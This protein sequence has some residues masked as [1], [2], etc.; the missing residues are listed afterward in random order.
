MNDGWRRYCGACGLALSPACKCGFVNTKHDRFCGGCGTTM[1]KPK[2]V[3]LPAKTIPID[4]IEE[5]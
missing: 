5:V 1:G 3:H 2:P 4:V